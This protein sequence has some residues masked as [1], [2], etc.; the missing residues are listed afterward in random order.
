MISER[1]VCFVDG[2]NLYHALKSLGQPYLQWLDLQLLFIRLKKSKS[3]I[4]SQIYYFSAY[5]NWKPDSCQRHKIYVKALSSHGIIP[6]MGKF[7]KKPKKCLNC[8]TQWIGHEEKETDVNIALKMFELAHKDTY[9]RAFLL[10]RDSDLAP[11][12]IAVKKN[13]P[14]KKITVFAPFNY[15]HSSELVQVSD[16]HK[17]IQLEHIQTS[18]FPEKVYDSQGNFIV[19]CPDKYLPADMAKI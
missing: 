7:K 13:F 17:T 10:S 6:I 12:V 19:S 5:P 11:A 16:S 15:R 1:V 18:L 9:D 2:F 4:I 3:Q 8:K 14:K